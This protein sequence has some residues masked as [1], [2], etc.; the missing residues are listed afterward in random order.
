M[1]VFELPLKSESR[2]VRVA[3]L[4]SCRTRNPFWALQDLGEL[5]VCD[6]GLSLTHGVDESRQALEAVLGLREIPA[7]FSP[8]IY[9]VVTPPE[10][11]RLRRTL[12]AGV[13]VFLLEV[14]AARQFSCGDVFLQQN[15]VSRELVQ[16][17]GAALQAWYR[18]IA[19]AGKVEDA[20]VDDALEKLRAAG[21]ADMPLFERLLRETRLGRTDAQAIERTLSAMMAMVPG[22]PWVVEGTMTTPGAGGALMED[23]RAL[24]ADLRAACERCGALFFDP[25]ELVEAYGPTVVFDDGG[26]NVHEYNPDVYPTVG[27][28]L[29]DRVKAVYPVPEAPAPPTATGSAERL[30]AALIDLHRRRLAEMGTAA[31]GLYAQYEQ[32]L[33]RNLLIGPRDRAAL[34]LIDHYLPEYDSYAVMRAG[35]GEVAFLLA[36][37]GRHVVA[38]QPNS[39]RRKAIEAGLT[40]LQKLGLIETGMMSVSPELTPAAPAA[41]RVLGVGL[42][43]SEFRDDAVAAPHLER[44]AKFT[45]LLIDPRLFLRLR[46][47]RAEQD[48]LLEALAERGF[49][50]RREYFADGLTW[51][52]GRR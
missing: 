11:D 40:H 45:D 52:R 24:N 13:D 22:R 2:G 33:D 5:K 16:K 27:R 9:G 47:G 35:L 26:A 48:D 30:N 50:V 41:G 19:R 21:Q 29:L 14:S 25:T 31:S 10:S 8:Y 18:R 32:L 15:F 49:G 37:S 34:A 38:H 42:D 46:E 6:H 7:E 44:A 4:G 39:N 23:R 36:A 17:H 28:A 1:L 20:I 3:A 12:G 51:L 43:T